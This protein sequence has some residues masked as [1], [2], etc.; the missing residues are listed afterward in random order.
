MSTYTLLP[1]RYHPEDAA[2]RLAT[3]IREHIRM[4]APGA[5]LVVS[6]SVLLELFVYEAGATEETII[7]PLDPRRDYRG[8]ATQVKVFFLIVPASYHIPEER[9]TM[10]METWRLLKEAQRYRIAHLAETLADD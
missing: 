1:S 3:E 5:L 8:E 9:E 7:D 10:D 2:K 4:L 6:I